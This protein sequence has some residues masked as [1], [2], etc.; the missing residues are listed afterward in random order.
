[1]IR[2]RIVAGLVAGV[3]IVGLA[4]C[5][6]DSK[7]SGTTAEAAATT[8]VDAATTTAKAAT[9]TTKAAT[10]TAGDTEDTT[11]TTDDTDITTGDTDISDDT[12][13]ELTGNCVALGKDFESVFGEDFDPTKASPDEIKDVFA[14][15]KAAVPSDLKDD[16]DTL[17]DAAMPLFTAMANS[18]GDITKAM[19]DPAVQKAM[20]AMS[21]ADVQAADKALE[22]W[23]SKGCPS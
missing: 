3:A 22:D 20:T 4:A 19:Q 13:P 21:S 11:A 7:S 1:M 16:I 23:T 17:T 10:T 15:L 2:Q 9:T 18:G 5:G 6:S 14:K 12:T 8:E